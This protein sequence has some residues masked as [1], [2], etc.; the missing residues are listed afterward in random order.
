MDIPSSATAPDAAPTL[1]ASPVADL[2]L[3]TAWQ[4]GWTL[5]F[6]GVLSDGSN[7]VEL[8]RVATTPGGITGFARDQDAWEHVV[9]RA[10]SGSALHRGALARV[11]Q[12]ERMLIEA[13]CGAW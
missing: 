6:L 5:T 10:R 1:S 12:T 9:T 8:T 3:P 4:E 7:R 2:D 13:S 11:D